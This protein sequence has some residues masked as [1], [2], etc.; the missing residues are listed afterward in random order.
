MYKYQAEIDITGRAIVAHELN[1]G[2][3]AQFAWTT[4]LRTMKHA[5]IPEV[6]GRVSGESSSGSSFAR[7][8]VATRDVARDGSHFSGKEKVISPQCQIYVRWVNIEVVEMSG[9]RV[10]SST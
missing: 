9:T 1:Q 8:S 10:L 4:C 3:V 6:F 7:L 2:V 5:V